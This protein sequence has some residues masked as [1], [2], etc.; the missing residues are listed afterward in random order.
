MTNNPIRYLDPS[1]HEGI[2]VSGGNYSN[3]SVHAGYD[4]NFIE[5]ALKKIMELRKANPNESI[6]WLI[7]DAGWSNAD[8]ANF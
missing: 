7:A 8:W 5:P 1:G 4:Y 3:D 2:V 6:A